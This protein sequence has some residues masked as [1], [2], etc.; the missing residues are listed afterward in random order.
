MPSIRAERLAFHYSAAVQLLSGVDLHLRPG[1]TALVGENGS[2]K[3]TFLRLLA[4]ELRPTSGRLVREPAG[5]LLVLC[6]QGIEAPGPDVLALAAATNGEARRLVG[7]LGLSPGQVERW[8]SLSPGER[9]CWQVGAALAR[10]PDCLLLDEPTNHLDAPTR[11]LL[12]AALRRF[13]GVGL[14]V[15]HDRAL[16]NA[17]TSVTLRAHGGTIRAWAGP[18]DAARAQGEAEARAVWRSRAAAQEASRRDARRLDEARRRQARAEAS[19]RSAGRSKGPR[20]HDARS[21]T[22]KT[23]AA[24]AEGRLGREVEVV[25][26]EAE[27]S[28]EAIPELPPERELGRS[29]FLAFERATRP[30]LLA[31]EAPEIERGSRTILRDVRLR[32]GREERVQ[33]RG[34]NGSGKSTLL[35]TLLGAADVPL[36]R[37]LY[38]PQELT[39][40]AAESALRTVRSLS[41]EPRG[42]V[43]GVVAALGV[44]PARLLASRQPSPGEARK[45]MLALGLGRSAW[46]LVLDEPTNHLDLPSVERLG[47]ALA[48][49]PGAILLVSHDQDFAARCTAAVW[50]IQNQRVRL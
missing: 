20:D 19:R 49:Y 50:R 24:W 6:P 3:S 10:G 21:V 38:L 28:A 12:L 22:R 18:Y 27:R 42:R 39:P 47:E 7:T 37:L 32:L 15:S 33:L 16:L 34:P 23:T 14:V 4:G 9:R 8:E 35:R 31:L 11:G 1:F 17:L 30:W 25:R 40:D 2:G 13:R 48:A 26:R 46:G 41:S 5:A 36:D 43:L 44:D 29:L 45:L